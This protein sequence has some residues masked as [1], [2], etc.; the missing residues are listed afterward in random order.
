MI[1]SLD[2]DYLISEHEFRIKTLETS[3]KLCS[4]VKRSYWLI[5]SGEEFEAI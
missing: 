2:G 1:L 4:T 5:Q 3:A